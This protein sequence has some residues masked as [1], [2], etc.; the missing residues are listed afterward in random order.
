MSVA[1]GGIGVK[2]CFRS[3]VGRTSWRDSASDRREVDR[4][5][6]KPETRNRKPEGHLRFLV[7]GFWFLVSRRMKSA[8]AMD[9]A[10]TNSRPTPRAVGPKSDLRFHFPSRIM[11]RRGGANVQTFPLFFG[12]PLSSRRVARLCRCAG[13][14]RHHGW[15]RA[16]GQQPGDRERCGRHPRR[17]DRSGRRECGHPARRDRDRRQR[18]PRLSRPHRRADVAR[19]S[20]REC[21]AQAR[22][23]RWRRA[24]AT[25]R[26][27]PGDRSFI[28]G[29]PRSEAFR[30]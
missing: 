1:K 13:R 19:I 16:S 4:Q 25:C 7:S 22:R 21:A 28:S 29:L 12:F 2:R 10:L 9:L 15:H 20:E 23:R 26:D 18:E 6:S 30:R 24:H 5:S 3:D 27:S 14:V 8:P 11:S 17:P